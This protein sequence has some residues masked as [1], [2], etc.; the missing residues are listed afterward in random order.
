MASVSFS[1]V[2]K[3]LVQNNGTSS[4]IQFDIFVVKKIG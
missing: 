1:G 3:Q 4:A 2:I